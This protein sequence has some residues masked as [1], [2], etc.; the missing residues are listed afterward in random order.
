MPTVPTPLLHAVTANASAQPRMTITPRITSQIVARIHRASEEGP[1]AREGGGAEQQI[2]LRDR[3][4]AHRRAHALRREEQA[5][6]TLEGELRH[7]HES[8]V[9]LESGAG[10]QIQPESAQLGGRRRVVAW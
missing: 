1:W 6:R 5:D 8:E 3:D 9:A 10:S 2:R 7:P 4:A